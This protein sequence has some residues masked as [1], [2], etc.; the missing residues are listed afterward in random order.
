MTRPELTLVENGNPVDRDAAAWFARLGA[1]DVSEDD[2]ARYRQWLDSDPAHRHAYQR[3]ERLWSSLAEFA[4]A[5]ELGELM[6]PSPWPEF[7][8]SPRPTATPPRR[9]QGWVLAAAAATLAIVVL[10]PLRML[11]NYRTTPTV[12]YATHRSERRSID[13]EDGTRM[14]LDAKTRVQVRYSEG[15]RVVVLREGR[16]FF[17]VAHDASRPFQ[18][19]S[20]QGGAMALGTQFETSLNGD[21]LDVALYEGSVALLA[22]GVES[23]TSDRLGTLVAGQKAR[24]R[25][26]RMALLPKGVER[27]GSPGWLIGS[28]VFSDTP[29]AEAA[30]EFN[31][32]SPSPIVLQGE[33]IGDYRITGV[34]RGSDADSFIEALRDV[35]GI[36][37][38]RE[39]DG[40]RVLLP[41]P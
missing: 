12:D 18:V 36:R 10:A 13:L 30:G 28:L 20:D 21:A 7:T 31:R 8:L 17:K 5:P 1:D 15:A 40:S 23:A 35:Y 3:L 9:W 4:H 14:D 24:I 39:A 6:R 33:G 2:R 38:R 19:V 26:D 29:L 16:A 37:S 41:P 25:G 11:P 22:T 32:Y 27:G 34:F